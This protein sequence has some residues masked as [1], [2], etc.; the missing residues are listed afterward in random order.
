M[1]V[2]SEGVCDI[3]SDTSH[4]AP[5]WGGGSEGGGLFAH[6]PGALGSSAGTAVWGVTLPG[7]ATSPSSVPELWV[8]CSCLTAVCH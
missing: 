5:E 4:D 7:Q 3:S 6:V 8:C 1:F 2:F